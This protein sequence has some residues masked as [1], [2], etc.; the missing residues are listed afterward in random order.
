MKNIQSIPKKDHPLYAQLKKHG[1]IYI[2]AERITSLNNIGKRI[3]N[4]PRRSSVYGDPDRDLGYIGI[5]REVLHNTIDNKEIF[6]AN[7]HFLRSRGLQGVRQYEQLHMVGRYVAGICGIPLNLFANKPQAA[8]KSVLRF[9]KYGIN[10]GDQIK[11]TAHTDMSLLTVVA[12][13]DSYLHIKD[14][15]TGK[16]TNKHEAG[17]ALVFVGSLLSEINKELEPLEHK[18]EGKIESPRFSNAF[19]LHPIPCTINNIDTHAY[20]DA[21]LKKLYK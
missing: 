5:K 1:H 12:Q 19:F 18:I 7:K 14:Q 13:P 15:E 8:D 9:L 2:P 16:W 20:C 11:G 4:N 21:K 17:C 10:N 3:F 6:H